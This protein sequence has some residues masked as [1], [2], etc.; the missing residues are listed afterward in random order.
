MR[1]AG[2]YT[3]LV[4]MP[5]K[6]AAA[7]KG[8]RSMKQNAAKRR[9]ETDKEQD[10]EYQERRE[11]NNIAVKKSRARSRARAQMTAT[12]VAEL[13]RDNTELEGKIKML[14]KELDLLKDLLVLQ[15]GKRNNTDASEDSTTSQSSSAATDPY[16]AA[17]NPDLINRDHG[18]VSPVK[19]P[20]KTH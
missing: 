17:A 7:M 10:C 18:Y 13:Q 1:E 6:R 19:R 2:F 20:R 14:S 12:K 3:K 9:S 5:P 4:V 11:R 15:A 8:G 16:V